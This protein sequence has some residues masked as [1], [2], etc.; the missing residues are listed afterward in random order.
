VTPTLVSLK[1]QP[2]ALA[3]IGQCLARSGDTPGAADHLSQADAICQRLNVPEGA[4]VTAELTGFRARRSAARLPRQDRPLPCRPIP[5]ETTAG[6]QRVTL[7]KGHGL[8]PGAAATGHIGA[9]PM[10]AGEAAAGI[11]AIEPAA[12]IIQSWCA[13]AQE[14]R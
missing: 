6:G 13:A 14:P 1:R 5:G 8:P 2:G 9:M 10:Y 7:P 4:E 11:S 3:G 12:Q